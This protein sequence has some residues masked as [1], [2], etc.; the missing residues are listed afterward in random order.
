V[1]EKYPTIVPSWERAWE[2]VVPFL[3][4]PAEIR[5]VI[6]TTNAIEGLHMQLRKVLKNRGHFP[7][8]EAAANYL[9]EGHDTVCHSLR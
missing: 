7:N 2:N 3:A 6:Y 8:N 5:K 9:E 4:F 1:G